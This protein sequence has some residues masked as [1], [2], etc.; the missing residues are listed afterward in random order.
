MA[1]PLW[2]LQLLYNQ[3]LSA[4]VYV[5]ALCGRENY[6]L[7]YQNCT[8]TYLFDT[9]VIQVTRVTMAGKV[10]LIKTDQKLP[11]APP[12]DYDYGN[13]NDSNNWYGLDCT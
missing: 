12:S 3:R 11:G 5:S 2:L 13:L 7:D 9:Q 10:D 8:S 1:Q 4:N 6:T